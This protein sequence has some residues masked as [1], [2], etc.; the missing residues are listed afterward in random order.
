MDDQTN[1]IGASSEEVKIV[2]KVPL[3]NLFQMTNSN[4]SPTGSPSPLPLSWL[5]Q[6]IFS[7]VFSCLSPFHCFLKKLQSLISPRGTR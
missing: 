1:H 6:N 5:F 7:K 3:L 4:M 2:P